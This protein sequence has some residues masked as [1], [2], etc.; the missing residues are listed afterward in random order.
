M[1][2]D[3]TST[4]TATPVI[5]LT[6]NE[7]APT[8]FRVIELHWKS[9][10]AT[11]D[12]PAVA[13]RD[14]RCLAAPLIQ[15]LVEPA[16]LQQAAQDAINE[17]QDSLARSIVEA[18][19]NTI[20]SVPFADLSAGALSTYASAVATS[21][22]L[23]GESI[24][25]WFDSALQDQL[26]SAITK[27][28]NL[29]DPTDLDMSKIVQGVNTYRSLFVELAAP[30]PSINKVHA[31]KLLLWAERATDQESSICS[32]ILAKLKLLAGKEDVQLLI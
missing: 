18:N 31:E 9:R 12:K 14:S 2:F 32:S 30:K 27:A 10:K 5:P 6:G 3:I 8:G 23:N 16:S 15:V 21:K 25:Q 28:L 1:S 7:T 29:T 26:I 17:L 11:A 19:Y 24:G 4:T 22:R 13:K 20:K